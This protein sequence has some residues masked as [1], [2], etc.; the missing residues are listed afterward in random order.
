MAKQNGYGNVNARFFNGFAGVNYGYNSGAAGSYP[1]FREF[2]S[3]VHL[4]VVEKWDKDSSWA[5]WRRG[6][7]YYTKSAFID[8]QV[9]ND[10]YDPGLEKTATNQPFIDANLQ[11]TL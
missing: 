10:N 8:L 9:K 11:S 5:R 3:S 7:E 4:S 1:K 6:L 2:G